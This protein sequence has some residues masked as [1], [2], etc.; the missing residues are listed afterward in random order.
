M[1]LKNAKVTRE[2]VLLKHLGGRG[3]IGKCGEFLSVI[4]VIGGGQI[5]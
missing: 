1:I 5:D 2:N 4:P 3:I